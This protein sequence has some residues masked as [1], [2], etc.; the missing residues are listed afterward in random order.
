MT[1]F[2]PAQQLWKSR[3]LAVEHHIPKRTV[4]T[5]T[6]RPTEIFTSRIM[7]TVHRCRSAPDEIRTRT[8]HGLSVRPLP[9]G[10][11]KHVA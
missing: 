9:I 7:A 4:F 10:I 11:Q 6:H 2:E 8:S 5:F 3:M 1:G